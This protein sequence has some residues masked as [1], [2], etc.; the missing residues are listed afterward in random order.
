MPDFRLPGGHCRHLPVH[1]FRVGYLG[2]FSELG[3][4]E[5]CR[6]PFVRTTPTRLCA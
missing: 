1:P 3:H 2:R 4:D 6:D 5:S